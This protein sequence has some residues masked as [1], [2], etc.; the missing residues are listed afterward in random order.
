MLRKHPEGMTI[1]EIAERIGLHRHTSTKYIHELMGAGVVYQRKV[2]PA[3]LCYLTRRTPKAV[4]Q[5]SVAK[6]NYIFTAFLSLLLI[7]A[8]V[9]AQ[10]ISNTPGM[11]VYPN[12][13]VGISD[14][15]LT[16]QVGQEYVENTTLQAVE[17]NSSSSNE[18]VE[19]PPEQ[20]TA[21][22]NDTYPPVYTVFG[23]DSSI[24]TVGD[25]AHFFAFWQDD[26][27]LN[28]WI[29]SWNA[30]GNWENES[31]SFVSSYDENTQILTRLGW[32]YLKT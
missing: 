26:F 20:V 14:E 6:I 16:E 11:L 13:T 1:S 32:K 7:V 17:E 5:K 10:N 29:F 24:H 9:L 22:L 23:V 4:G 8:L 19:I 28:E 21:E 30:S 12:A 18:T 15:N 31:Y 27:G 3:R 25:A 2:G